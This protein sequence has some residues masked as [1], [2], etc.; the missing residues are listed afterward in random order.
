MTDK[1]YAL[2]ALL[3]GV[4]FLR[5][6]IRLSRTRTIQQARGVLRAS[7]LYLP[8]LYAAL[9]SSGVLVRR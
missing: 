5:A 8:L 9:L 6:G 2:A 3:L 4:V 1:V 7:V